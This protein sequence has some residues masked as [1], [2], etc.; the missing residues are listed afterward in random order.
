MKHMLNPKDNRPILTLN[1]Q[2]EWREWLEENHA[3]SDG[4]WLLFYKKDSGKK[5]KNH[6]CNDSHHEDQ[7]VFGQ[8]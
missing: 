2:S 3:S 4:V 5:M 7:K 8:R 6:T 1:S